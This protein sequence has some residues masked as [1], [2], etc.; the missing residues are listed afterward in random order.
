MAEARNSE[1]LP[2]LWLDLLRGGLSDKESVGLGIAIGGLFT[3]LRLGFQGLLQRRLGSTAYLDGV[4]RGLNSRR[5]LRLKFL[6]RGRGPRFRLD[7]GGGSRIDAAE[8][9]YGIGH[10]RGPYGLNNPIG[11]SEENF[12][13]IPDG[14]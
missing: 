2:G 11:R 6:G 3:G 10:D 5:S 7:C 13:L 1:T 9:G 4:Y 14:A 8:A 12:R